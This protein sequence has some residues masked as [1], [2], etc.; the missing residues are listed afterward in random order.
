MPSFTLTFTLKQHTPLIHFQHV[1]SGATLRASEVKPKLD[2][3]VTKILP[4]AYPAMWKKYESIVNNCYRE[5][6]NAT[7][8][9]Y[10]LR[11]NAEFD[12]SYIVANFIKD[13][14]RHTAENDLHL[15]FL[16]NTPYFAD[17]EGI[18]NGLKRNDNGDSLFGNG[19]FTGIRKGQMYKNIQLSV[20]SWHAGLL[21]MMKEVI[22]IFFFNYNFG[23]RQTKGFGCFSVEGFDV[24]KMTLCLTSNSLV[25]AVYEKKLLSEES[26]HDALQKIQADYQLLKSGRNFG[27]YQKS[28]LWQYLCKTQDNSWEKRMVKKEIEQNHP[29]VWAAI[30]SNP[31]FSYH[32]IA[33]CPNEEQDNYQFIRALLGLAEQI[34]FLTIARTDKVSVRISDIAG[35]IDRYPSPI[36]FKVQGDSI[37]L[38]GKEVE[39]AVFSQLKEEKGVKKNVK[40]KYAF[41]LQAKVSGNI[42]NVR[43]GSPLPVPANFNM[44]T[45]LQFALSGKNAIKDYLRKK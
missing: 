16:Y 38:I 3:F 22:P 15:K 36:L 8:G 24:N 10:K 17:A 19:D 7:T 41:D 31:S 43:L 21:E 25:T 37:F 30:K 1:Q 5:A 40:R 23:T 6:A 11:I 35:E 4:A 13:I 20:F 44:A 28:I 14:D 45:F 18:K 33:D 42:N 9:D 2:R 27:G 29:I 39:K 26:F 32:R 34:D 12:E